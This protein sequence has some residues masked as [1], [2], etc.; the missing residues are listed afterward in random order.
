MMMKPL[1]LTI[2]FVFTF[3]YC[4]FCQQ[5][6]TVLV[7]S[8]VG[9]DNIVL[10]KTSRSVVHNFKNKKYDLNEGRGIACGIGPSQR[11]RSAEYKNDTIGLTFYFSTRWVRW[12][13][14]TMS[15]MRLRKITITKNAKTVS[16][17]IIGKST[18][19]DVVALLGIPSD[20]GTIEEYKSSGIGFE[21][22]DKG[23]VSSIEVFVPY[24]E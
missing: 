16:G 15:K 11:N 9:V 20:N 14:H 4:A 6:D 21:Y 18:R 19:K 22:N 7:K 13:F 10:L 12:P 1:F 24:V 23:V 3:F 8:G 5:A 17:L 2:V